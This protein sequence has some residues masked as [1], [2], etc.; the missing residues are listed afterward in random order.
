VEPE[1][2]LE[3]DQPAEVA[4]AVAPLVVEPPRAVDPWWAAGIRESLDD[5]ARP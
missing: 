1:L 2:V 3:P 4:A 5:P